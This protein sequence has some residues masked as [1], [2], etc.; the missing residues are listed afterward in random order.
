LPGKFLHDYR[1]TFARNAICGGVTQVVTMAIAGWRG[2]SVFSGDSV[3]RRYSITT[4]DDKRE[5]L[6]R[7][8]EYLNAQPKK[9]NVAD[10]R[11][12]SADA[13]SDRTRTE[14]NGR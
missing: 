6:R 9:N 13:N 7:Q 14:G 2:D 11:A 5:V 1:R 10:F 8:R 3:F 4:S 12:P